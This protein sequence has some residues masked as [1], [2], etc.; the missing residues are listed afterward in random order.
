LEINMGSLV[1]FVPYLVFCFVEC[2]AGEAPALMAA[3][4][5]S[6]TLLA[7]GLWGKDQTI[8]RLDISSAG[9]FI[10]L[11]IILLK[12]GPNWSATAVRVC[13]DIGILILTLSSVAFESPLAADYLRG[14]FAPYV[15]RRPE[16]DALVYLVTMMWA[17]AFAALVAADLFSPHFGSHVIV[18]NFGIKLGA[19]G[20]AVHFADREKAC[21]Q[22]KHPIQHEPKNGLVGNLVRSRGFL[23]LRHRRENAGC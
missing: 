20:L 22:A 5:T 2:A 4:V 23:F 17:A 11:S 6:A 19:I 21:F 12:L 18:F 15:S 10:A 9:L 7:R 8:K 3:A 14:R 13:V 1:V 16:F